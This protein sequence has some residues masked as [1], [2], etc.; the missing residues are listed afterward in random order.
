MPANEGRKQGPAAMAQRRRGHSRER[1]CARKA[2]VRSRPQLAR[3]PRRLGAPDGQCPAGSPPNGRSARKAQ[4]PGRHSAADGKVGW[5]RL[6][7]AGCRGRHGVVCGRAC[8]GGAS[9]E[10]GVARAERQVPQAGCRSQQHGDQASQAAIVVSRVLGRVLG[11]G[12]RSWATVIAD[13]TSQAHCEQRF[14]QQR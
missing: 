6:V 9:R 11:R 8:A 12:Q 4:C 14:R 1:Y 10:G 7:V 5:W 2:Q 3:C 13:R